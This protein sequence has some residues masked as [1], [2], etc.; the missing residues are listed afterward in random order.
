MHPMITIALG[1]ARDAAE[2]IAHSSDRLDRIEIIEDSAN[3]FLSSM[4]V[5]ADKTVLYH[6]QKAYPDHSFHSRVS[7][8]TEG[9]DKSTVWLIDPLVGNRNFAQ[10]FTQ[11]AVSIACQ[12][13]GKVTHAV[14]INPMLQEEYTCSRGK[15]AQLNAR[16]L[17]VNTQKELGKSLISLN[18]NNKQFQLS[19]NIHQ[20]LAQKNASVRITGCT[21][22]DMLNCAAG[23]V[24]AGWSTVNNSLGIAAA[25]LMIQEAGGLLGDQSGNPDLSKATEIIYGNPKCF[26]QLLKL[27]QT[28]E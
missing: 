7:G 19:A 25:S 21:A 12:I 15:G 1:A 28:S 3:N 13:D 26:R 16:R 10:G 14:I 5:N 6:L 9:K 2:A 8:Y 24:S 22:L 4:D 11:F 17:R 23:R 27:R 20:Q 18:A